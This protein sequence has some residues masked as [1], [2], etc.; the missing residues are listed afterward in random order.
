MASQP[1]PVSNPPATPAVASGAVPA[2]RV[3]A[4]P[5][6]QAGRSG[7]RADAVFRSASVAAAASILVILAA[8]FVLLVINAWPSITRYGFSFA[9]R[10]VWD[11]VKEQ[12]G[13]LPYIYG[14][15]VTS[16]VAL[17]LATPLSVGA[18]IYVAEYAPPPIRTPVTFTIEMLAAIPSIIYGLWGFF[19]LTPIMRSTVEPALQRALGPI[20]VIGGLFQG[21]AIGKD[22]FTGGV[23]LAI[24]ITPTIMAIS[25][26]VI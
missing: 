22:L 5:R 19:I 8:L 12:F 14:T 18:A 13:A 10:S 6:P 23:I 21:P 15:L 17:V 25:R 26:E 24:M 1:S 9:T 16:I 2:A 11:N 20:P 7:Q 4:P 3:G